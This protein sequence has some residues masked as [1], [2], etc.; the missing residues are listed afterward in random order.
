[1]TE[2]GD[3]V[4]SGQ[5]SRGGW[6]DNILDISSLHLD[7]DTVEPVRCRE[8]GQEFK[9]FCK[10]HM[11]ELCIT[12]SR[13]EH[14]RCKTVIGI[15]AAAENIYSKLHDEK[16]TKSV[17]DL[18]ERFKDLKAAGEDIKSKLSIQ[19]NAAIDKVKQQ[20]KD[21]DT[22]L[23]KL[24]AKTVAEIRRKMEEYRKHVE[25]MIQVCEASLSSLCTRLVDIERT[26]SEGNKE[27]RFIA[28]NK[29]SIQTNR[30]CNILFDLKKEM[31]DINVNFEP[32]VTLPDKFKSFGTVSTEMFTVI[33]VFADTTPIYTGEM[34]VKH[35]IVGGKVPL[36]VSFNVLQGGGKVVLDH[37][38]DKIQLYNKNNSFVTETVLP[39]KEGEKCNSVVLNNNAEALV[40]TRRLRVFKVMIDDELAVSEIMNKYGIYTMIKYGEDNLCVIWHKGQG[41]LCILDKNTENIIQTILKD[42]RELFKAPGFLGFSADKNTIYVLDCMKGCYGITLDGRIVFNYQNQEA[43]LYCGLVVDSD[44]LFIVTFV[45]HK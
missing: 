43:E 17:K 34:E 18:T 11:T 5:T 33:D 28:I 23:D 44:G 12:C 9:H 41:Q 35:D 8:H 16:I 13:V 22:Y 24:E 14:R 30:C 32:N 4:D 10:T 45:D 39:V 20:R 31:R 2:G 40:T 36:V 37:N 6:R 26:M 27:D 42:D 29:V 21:I 38:N 25:E 1:M 7:S 3:S 19:T 15:K